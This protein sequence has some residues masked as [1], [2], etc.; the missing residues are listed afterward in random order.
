MFTGSS[1]P[2]LPWETRTGAKHCGP[3]KQCLEPIGF[4]GMSVS[5]SMTHGSEKYKAVATKT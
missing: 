5:T 2:W 1:Q 3:E 4:S